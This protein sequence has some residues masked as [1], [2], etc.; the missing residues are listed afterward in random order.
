MEYK[1]FLSRL[2]RSGSTLMRSIS[3]KKPSSDPRGVTPPGNHS[4]RGVFDKDD[5]GVLEQLQ[6]LLP[7]EDNARFLLEEMNLAQEAHS[8][9]RKFYTL[10]RLRRG[11]SQAWY[12]SKADS[13][14]DTTRLTS[15]IDPQ[16]LKEQLF[17]KIEEEQ[18]YL[19][20]D[21]TLAGLAYELDIE[22]Y[23]L[24]RFLNHH[25]HTTFHDLIN[26]YRVNAAKERLMSAPSETILDIAFAVGFNSKASFN[27]VF[28]K[29]TGTTPSKF[30]QRETY[31]L[32]PSDSAPKQDSR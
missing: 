20:E 17:Q 14:R 15:S 10:S 23:Q 25:L 32:H 12:L 6:Q 11:S 5:F 18:L 9:M 31:R 26:A 16:R 13:R 24:T 19:L 29:A 21:L 30:R 8:L 7:P 2:M 28:K 1:K 22:P 4:D 3:D 27:R